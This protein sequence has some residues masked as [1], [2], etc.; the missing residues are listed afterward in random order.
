MEITQ[1]I[2]VP[3]GKYTFCTPTPLFEKVLK[4]TELQRYYLKTISSNKII[5]EENN[6]TTVKD[7]LYI[8]KLDQNTNFRFFTSTSD[9]S[10]NLIKSYYIKEAGSIAFVDIHKW[11]NYIKSQI[12]EHYSLFQTSAFH[13]NTAIATVEKSKDNKRK[14][15][16]TSKDKK[17]LLAP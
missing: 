11:G 13:M 2:I 10:N 4:I 16:I 5:V 1:S 9:Y 12:S 8:F 17:L 6:E 15:V 7:G 3:K 14:L